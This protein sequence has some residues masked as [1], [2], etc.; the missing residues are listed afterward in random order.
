MELTNERWDR[1]DVLEFQHILKTFEN[2]LKRE[3]SNNILKTDLPVLG[4]TT[5]T[6]KDIVKKIAEG[7]Y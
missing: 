5:A 7:D 3:W 6:M 4:M 1:D 2:P